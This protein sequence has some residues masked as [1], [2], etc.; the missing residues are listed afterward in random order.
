MTSAGVDTRWRPRRP[1]AFA[2]AAC[3][4]ALVTLPP[5]G[6]AQTKGA[7]IKAGVKYT[8]EE[9]AEIRELEKDF[10]LFEQASKDFRQTVAGIVQRAYEEQKQKVKA[11]FDESIEAEEKEERSRRLA[12]IALYEDFLRRHP[13]DPK[14]TPDVI[15]RLAELYFEKSNDEYLRAMAAYDEQLIAYEDKKIGTAPLQPKQDY[16]ASIALYLRLTREFPTYRFLD[17][18]LY[19]LG[20]CFGEQGQ[21]AEAQAAYLALVCGNKHTPPTEAALV[22]AEKKEYTPATR[23]PAGRFVDPYAD[24]EPITKG[25][26]FNAEAW[27]RIG[28]YHFDYNEL[29]LAIAAYRRVLDDKDSPYYDKALYKLAWAYYRADQFPEAVKGFDD[30]VKYADE[31][32]EKTGKFG[33]D[34]RAEA[35]QYLAIC[36]SEED[37]DGDTLPD[38]DTGFERIERFYGGARQNEPHVPEVYQRLGDIF[39]EINKY[40]EAIAV[41]KVV[42]QRWPHRAENPLVQERVIQ[43][44]DRDRRF[45]EAIKE[46]DAY[47]K[48]FGANSEWERRN[49]ADME[50]LQHVRSF[51]ENSLIQAAVFHHKAAQEFRKQCI[52]GD[53][54]KCQLAADEY[55]LAS[56]AYQGY[57]QTF[58]NTKNSYEI[59]FYLAESYYYSQQFALAAVA[60]EAVRDSNLDNRYQQESAFNATKAYEEAI[61]IEVRAGRLP[62]PPIPKND[63]VQKPVVKQEIPELYRKLQAAYDHYE[64]SLPKDPKTPAI[65]YKAAEIPYRFLRLDE[66]RPRFEQIYEKYCN[67]DVS[68]EALRA[69]IESHR[70]ENNETAAM[71]YV[72]KQ[73]DT[74]CGSAEKRGSFTAEGKALLVNIQFRDAQKLFDEKKYEQAAAK[75]VELIDKFPTNPD[76]PKALNNAAVAYENVQRYESATRLYERLW[77]DY[78]DSEFADDALFRS[79]INYQRFFEFDQAVTSYLILAESPKFKNSEHRA[80]ALFNAAVILEGDQNYT[81]AAELYKKHADV[82]P[83]PDEAAES[84][85]RAIKCYSKQKNID[86]MVSAAKEFQKR[87]GAQPA[88]A[89]HV[90]EALYMMAAAYDEKKDSRNA[91]KMMK[92]TVSEFTARRLAPAS[93][94]A[95]WAARAGF[96]LAEQQYEDFQKMTISGDFEG[97]SKQRDKM[98]VTAKQVQDAYKNVQGYKRVTWTLAAMT[99]EGQVYEHFARQYAEG[100]RKAPMPKEMKKTIDK[101]KR[102]GASEDDIQQVLDQY[103]VQVDEALAKEVEPLEKTAQQLY[104]ASLD[105]G[106]RFGV[107]NEWTKLAR[108]R[109]NAYNPT[110]YPLLKD[111]RVDYQLD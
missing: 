21:E 8:D 110:E 39:F 107:S 11:R 17:G 69:I 59:Q 24:C 7:I 43:A 81:R 44:L 41:Y 63:T 84:Y 67:D 77:K 61:K 101:F 18:A 105:A 10:V 74:Q 22:V 48:M 12:A 80:N 94:A 45:E 15:Y 79:A 76:V 13:S 108:Q 37:W 51:E 9:H 14:W 64:K 104:K 4:A 31:Q 97:L 91:D 34:L 50:A 57:L 92:Q 29:E 62:D 58:P 38:A 78:P 106:A 86:A 30:L 3:C 93:E 85:F 56:I 90:V 46:R 68:I 33:S 102:A 82:A 100:F 49:R 28:E 55:S 72:Q 73:A 40:P 42:L 75:Y 35:I 98:A 16:H 54:T 71:P 5:A 2:L 6:N 26:K 32:K 99:R 89:A 70:M 52:G 66:A 96:W 27:T 88:Q 47:T 36:F 103:Q 53:A 23:P 95:E 19:L 109:L 65:A 20:Y 1:I 60:Y 83:K 25:G 111:E 87:Y